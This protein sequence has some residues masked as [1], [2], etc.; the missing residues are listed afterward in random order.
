MSVSLVEVYVNLLEEGSPVAR[1]TQAIDLGNGTYKLLPTPHY[2][3]EDEIWEFLPGTV[4]RCA[5][6][7]IAPGFKE[8]E[9]FLA[10]EKVIS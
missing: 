3:P 8:K 6:S 1:P 5:M 7:P 2:D 10:V 9:M 4:V